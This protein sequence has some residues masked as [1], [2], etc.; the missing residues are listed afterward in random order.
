MAFPLVSNS[1][2]SAE[3][4]AFFLC[5]DVAKIQL[6]S[7]CSKVLKENNYE[8]CISDALSIWDSTTVN[9]SNS[10]PALLACKASARPQVALQS[11]ELWLFQFEFYGNYTKMHTNSRYTRQ[12]LSL[13]EIKVVPLPCH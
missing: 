8:N 2:L 10:A 6:F 9:N 5:F 12:F 1:G 4:T 3:V 7:L 13:I 11:K